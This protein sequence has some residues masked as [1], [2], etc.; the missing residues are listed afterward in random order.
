MIASKFEM[1]KKIFGLLISYPCMAILLAMYAV[2]MAVATFYEVSHGTSAVMANFYHSWWFILLQLLLVI[3]FVGVSVKA[4]LIERKLWGVLLLH[5]AFVV[6]LAGAFVTHTISY[7]GVM[8][9]REGETSSTIYQRDSKGGMIPMEVPFSVELHDFVLE[10]Y[11]GSG[12]PSSFESHVTINV[13]GTKRE[14]K[15]Y[16]NNIAYV[17]SYRLYQSS[18]DKDEMGTI[19]TVNKDLSGTIISYFGYILMTLGFILLFFNKN[20]HVRALTRKLKEMSIAPKAAILALALVGAGNCSLYSQEASAR[21]LSREQG[22]VP[23][24]VADDF[25]A[26]LVQN[27]SGR[28]EP[29]GSY[30]D[31]LLRKVHRSTGYNSYTA[32]QVILGMMA[33]PYYWAA[34]PLIYISSKPLADAVGLKGE[35]ASYNQMF[36]SDGRYRLAGLVE[37]SYAREVKEQTKLD[38]EIIKLDEKVNIMHGIFERVMLPIFPNPYSE[39]DKWVSPNDDHSAFQSRDSVFVSGVFNYLLSENDMAHTSKEWSGSHKIID[40]MRTYQQAMASPDHIIDEAKIKAEL[41]YN[42]YNIFKISAIGYLAIGGIL[43]LALLFGLL[44]SQGKIIQT[45]TRVLPYLVVL[46]FLYETFGIALRWYISGRAPW[47]N[48]YESM[49]YVGWSAVLAGLLF[50]RRSKTTLAIATIMGGVVV[51]ISQLNFMDP[52]ITPLVPVLKSYWLMFHVAIITASY[53]FFGVSALLGLVSLIISVF[54][55]KEQVLLK[56]SELNIINYLSLVVGLALLSI[57]VFLGA[58][59]ANESWGRYWGWDPKE[60]WALITMVVYAFIIHCRLVPRLRG[61]YTF[62]VL[63]VF[64]LYSVIMTFFG[65]NYYLSGMHSYGSSQSFNLSAV[66]YVSVFVFLIAGLAA[67]KRK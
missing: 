55:K 6:I 3:N 66:I 40:M 58:V 64:G 28:V 16:M 19:L 53:G 27:P 9:I 24:S 43:L 51:M 26:L 59:W 38:K 60:T 10:R 15:I 1:I 65:V 18:Y 11:A 52:E 47:T 17:G 4:R 30:A 5:W 20:S 49:V 62:A 32:T 14:E 36:N 46:F 42:N 7:E 21:A 56:I 31:K 25:A 33:S 48:T 63:S 8:H 50:M 67:F 61:G 22:V 57:G 44:G 37:K 41:Y 23:R 12:S 34:E 29:I 54:S 13:D 2:A 39:N 45:I 35:Y